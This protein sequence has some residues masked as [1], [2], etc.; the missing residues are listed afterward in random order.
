[1]E[2][3]RSCCD[4]DHFWEATRYEIRYDMIAHYPVHCPLC[5][6]NLGLITSKAKFLLVFLRSS[7]GDK[8]LST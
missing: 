6:R 2:V 4:Q 1:M 5:D 7:P 3:K 8:I